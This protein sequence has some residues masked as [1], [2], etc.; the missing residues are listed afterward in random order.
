[1]SETLSADPGGPALPR[2]GQSQAKGAPEGLR[3]APGV[4]PP[5]RS[6]KGLASLSALGE[7]PAWLPDPVK[8]YLVHTELGVPLRELARVQGCHA[9]T[10]LRQIRRAESRRDDPLIDEALN[11]LGK[12]SRAHPLA[13][14]RKENLSMPDAEPPA[15]SRSGLARA[16]GA[17]PADEALLLREAPRILRRL[18][19]PGAQLALAADL[20]RAAVLRAGPD[21]VLV[22]TAIV[23]REI[24]Q[25]LALK[26]W[27]ACRKQGR[28]TTYVL[29]SA[30]KMA[31][32]RFAGPGE[33]AGLAPAGFAEG[34]ARFAF[35]EAEEEDAPRRG[36]RYQAVESPVAVLAR[37]RDRDGKPFL[38]PELVWAAERLREDYEVAQMGPQIGQ[39][40]AKL[41]SGLVSGGQSPGA[42]A[43]ATAPGR[44]KTRVAAALADLGPGLAD[45]VLRCCCHLEGLESAE[46]DMGWAARSGKI[47]LRIALQRLRR[48]YMERYG[49]SGPLIG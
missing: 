18:A 46:Q 19:E 36:A 30:G 23:S 31:L 7:V 5:A 32:R 40:W 24:A 29:T 38:S 6:R 12:S 35:P 41:V 37:R 17:G 20:G 22:Q 2:T 39:D 21:G 42:E 10:I 15:S 13:A 26:D 4:A 45:V 8:M 33:G 27:I 34:A 25:A 44:A 48:H 43:E 49:A 3:R 9:S 1:M 28:I 11:A 47:V 16:G 14:R